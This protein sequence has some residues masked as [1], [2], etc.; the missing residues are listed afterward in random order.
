MI[1]YLSAKELAH[2]LGIKVD[3]LTRWRWETKRQKRAI[4]PPWEDIGR[5]PL[6]QYAPRIRY[7]LTDVIEWEALNNI[8]PQNPINYG[9]RI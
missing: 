6:N 7:R 5:T 4:G 1:E 9:K 2:R 3:T 8:Q